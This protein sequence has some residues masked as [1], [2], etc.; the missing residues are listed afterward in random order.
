M[1][2]SF[3]G[4]SHKALL[5]YPRIRQLLRGITYPLTHWTVWRDIRK[6]RPEIVHVQWSRLPEF[7]LWLIRQIQALQIP[8]VHTVHDIVPLFEQKS[9]EKLGQIY[10]LVDALILHTEAN[11]RELLHQF[12]DL[13][14]NR[15]HIVPLIENQRNFFDHMDKKSARKHLGISEDVPV[16]VFLA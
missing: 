10:K 1:S 12:P 6:F 15:L 8:V 3:R 9:V 14:K 7:D 13:N 5:K 2:A 16:I 4:I 11:Q